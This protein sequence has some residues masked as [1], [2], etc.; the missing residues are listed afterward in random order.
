MDEQIAPITEMGLF[1]PGDAEGVTRLFRTVYSEG[2]PVRLVYDAPALR[3]AFEARENIPVVARTADG[4]VAAYVALYRSSPNPRVY[5]A[6]QG[7]VL[8]AYR[9]GGIAGRLREAV[10][11]V[12]PDLEIDV[13]FGEAVCN[14]T[15]MQKAWYSPAFP[16]M[17][18]EVDL[19]PAEAYVQ[20]AS[21]TGRVSAVA[22]FEIFKPEPH[23]VYAPSVYEEALRFL[24]RNL[25]DERKIEP[26]TGQAGSAVQTVI[27]TQVFQFASVAR[28]AVP[29]TGNDFDEIFGREEQRL[30]DGGMAVIQVWLNLGEPWIDWAVNALRARGYFL[31]GVLPRWFG[32][33]GLL[34]QKPTQ[35]PNW[36]GIHLY[37]ERSK[38]VL[39]IVKGD[40]RAVRR[41]Q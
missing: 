19:M 37:S 14:H 36:E 33:D 15:H 3:A 39:A 34:M 24:Y 9:G 12:I 27:T 25:S 16:T 41:P 11:S 13:L 28:V 32:E 20:E 1:R 18:I 8:P 6:G 17:A 26:S 4:E 31:G 40:W 22:C 30:L 10:H 21:A 29:T 35:R 38:E 2:Y 7:L 23:L 5:E